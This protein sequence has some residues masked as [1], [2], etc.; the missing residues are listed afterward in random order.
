MEKESFTPEEVNNII[1]NVRFQE[2]LISAIL[3]AIQRSEAAKDEPVY[4]DAL[5][6]LLN[7]RDAQRQ[8]APDEKPAPKSTEDTESQ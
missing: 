5:R 4:T 3:T 8:P 1:M 6:T 2:R 7:A